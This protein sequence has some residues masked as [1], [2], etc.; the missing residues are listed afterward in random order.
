MSRGW[1][2]LIVGIVAMGTLVLLFC[3][4]LYRMAIG[5]NRKS[6]L[7]TDRNMPK[8]EET[9]VR[10]IK[11][12]FREQ[13]FE[14]AE[15]VS[16][17]GLK[18]RAHYLESKPDN[19][20]AVILA[21]GYSGKGEDMAAF[22]RFY[23]ENGFNVLMPDNRGHGESDGHYIGFG[24]HDR[25]DYVRWIG[26][27]V[28]RIGDECRILLHGV[29]MGGGTV[30]MTSGEPLP[31]QVKGIVA[32][33]AYSSVK[34]ILKYQM[35]QM[36]KLPSFPLLPIT[37]LICKLRAGYFFGEASVLKQLKNCCK[38]VLLIH[39]GK[40]TFV[41][42]EMAE[43]IFAAIPSRKEKLIVPEAQHGTSF[44]VDSRSYADSVLRFIQASFGK[45]AQKA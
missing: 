7:A 6:F 25:K 33:C 9:R 42:T 5:R 27:L 24:W 18:L 15:I 3:W 43:E 30:L 1:I 29:S 39:G 2:I 37:S 20:D 26:Y 31:P 22:A 12:W 40:D 34:G 14:K 10:E 32:D 35:K 11:E 41:P 16:D 17:D 23:L 36:F 45:Q 44:L 4:S 38:P 28:N 19:R 8:V 13:P 21:H